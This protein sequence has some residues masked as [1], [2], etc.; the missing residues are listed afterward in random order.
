MK[1]LDQ[2]K[3]ENADWLETVIS[4]YANEMI[5][6]EGMESHPSD[7][8]TD[9]LFIAREKCQNETLALEVKEYIECEVMVRL[10]KNA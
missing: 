4:D 3:T 5:F 7:Y 2:F 10:L 1:T 6:Q 8:F 9:T